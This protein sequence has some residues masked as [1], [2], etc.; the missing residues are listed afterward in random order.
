MTGQP[1]RGGTAFSDILLDESAVLRLQ[2][3]LPPVTDYRAGREAPL[4]PADQVDPEAEGG[5]GTDAC[6]PSRLR[7]NLTLPATK[8]RI[9]DEPDIEFVE[10]EDDE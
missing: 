2:K 7:M 8:T 3:G 9:T 5:E 10:L 4:T 6:S 1:I